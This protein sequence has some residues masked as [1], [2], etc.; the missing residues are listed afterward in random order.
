MQ[1]HIHANNVTIRT[2]AGLSPIPGIH[3]G[4]QI[5]AT[6][7]ETKVA[8]GIP[9][10]GQMWPEQGGVVG[11]FMPAEGGE[12]G[13]WLIVPQDAEAA[14]P[15]LKWGG[16]GKELAGLSARDGLANTKLLCADKEAHPAA[17]FCAGLQLHGFNDFY[18]PSRREASLLAATVP[19]LFTPGY[20][21]TSTQSSANYAFVQAFSDGH[22]YNDLKGNEWRVRA[23][24]RF[25]SN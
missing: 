4:E 2:G 11:G 12:P 5:F 8:P 9:E 16:Y 19:H 22:Q 1:I 15:E 24:R 20:H 23:V 25:I 3:A 14:T 13:Y 10:A 6:L 21:W 7:A 18:L 17:K